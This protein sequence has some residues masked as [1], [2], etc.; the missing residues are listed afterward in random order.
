MAA[1]APAG[2]EAGAAANAAADPVVQQL[3]GVDLRTELRCEETGETSVED[4]TSFELKCNITI[5]VNHLSEGLRLGL[6]EDREKNSTQLGQLAL[7]KVKI[8]SIL[9]PPSSIL[10]HFGGSNTSLILH[11]CKPETLNPIP[12]EQFARFPLLPSC[13]VG[14]LPMTHHRPHQGNNVPSIVT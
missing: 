2:S 12:G 1:Q 11:F 4:S 10:A 8:R 9:F 3:M 14:V 5:D 6:Q 7:F 13:R